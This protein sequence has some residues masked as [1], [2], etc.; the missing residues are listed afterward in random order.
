MS[1]LENTWLLKL[2]V[3]RETIEEIQGA[4]LISLETFGR[5]V[6]CQFYAIFTWN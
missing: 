1:N 2:N 6:T 4:K 5:Y 3:R